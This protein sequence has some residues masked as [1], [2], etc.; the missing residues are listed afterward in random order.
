MTCFVFVSI[1]GESR[2]ADSPGDRLLRGGI[3]R[4]AQ[5]ADASG[6]LPNFIQLLESLRAE[7]APILTK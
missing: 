1:F 7:N 4:S 3:C 5:V 6:E 2:F